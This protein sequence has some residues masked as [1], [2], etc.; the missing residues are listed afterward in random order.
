M[1]ETPLRVLLVEDHSSHARL[2]REQ[3]AAAP[4]ASII[5]ECVDRLA[6][7]LARLA[8]GGID[9]ILLDLTLPDGEGLEG[10][11]R[12]YA[13]APA[14]PII[15]LTGLP[16][17]ALA[18][19]AV[20]EGA[21]DYLVKGQ[22]DGSL[23]VRALLYAIERKRAEVELEARARELARKTERLEALATL[24]R[25]VS[26]SLDPPQV[27]NFVVD[28][29]VR[30][31]N[32]NLARLWLWD[33]A[34]ELLC[35]AA[36]TGEADL[37]PS[38]C[39]VFRSGE[40]LVGLA[41]AQQEALTTEGATTDP[42]SM[43]KDWAQER[44]TQAQTAVPLLIGGRAL[45]VLTVARRDPK[46]FEDDELTLL[47]S[48]A[49]QTAIAIENAR[50]YE[51]QLLAA[52]E[53][54]AK[55]EARTR[56]LQSANSRLQEALHRAKEASRTKS[57]FL[58]T[59]SHEL[60]TPLN[61]IIGFSELLEDQRLGA[62]NPKQ[63]RYVNHVLA[64][65]RHLLTLIND[66]LDL[67]KIEAGRLTLD[68]APLSLPDVLTAALESLRPQADAKGVGLRLTLE[69][70][71][72]T[73]VVDAVRFNQILYNLL[74]NAVKFTP[75]GGSVSV[76]ARIVHSSPFTVHREPLPVS[77]PSTVIRE[78]DRDFVE[79]SV[80]D[81]GIGIKAEDLP[82]LF[83]EFTQLD[84]SLARRHQGTGLG[85]ALTK[86]IVELH[87]GT[88]QAQSAGEGQGS[89]FIVTLP[90]QGPHAAAPSPG[91]F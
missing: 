55:V 43:H 75:G 38:E 22:V 41:F 77:E 31:L 63:R 76:S 19:T 1:S 9:A 65:G 17:E 80:Q 89:T 59:M 49:S 40:G 14:V 26:A 71:P 42:H 34:A 62:L 23:L 90:L 52:R 33:E 24:S 50:L 87:G 56:E 30:L 27:L 10:F 5:L 25:T 18:I 46:P 4:E 86:R 44:G 81:T 11:R 37:V 29:T 69:T 36:S 6:P 15:V 85:L 91:P 54:E 47:R 48:F 45:G 60:R 13:Q 70:C 12:V 88:I 57:R 16:D 66:I 3:L 51:A 58:A 28:A 53:L 67:A 7:G 79:I 73:L 21:Q 68:P 84:A 64:S 78:P 20:R 8:A 82:K 35:L 2:I 72:K 32:V 39:G 83:Q 61:A 74:S